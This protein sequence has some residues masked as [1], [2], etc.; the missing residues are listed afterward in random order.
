M[1]QGWGQ[2]AGALKGWG[3]VAGEAPGGQ[4][5]RNGHAEVTGKRKKRTTVEEIKSLTG[6]SFLPQLPPGL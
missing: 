2:R 1:E 5:D 6:H 4:G 3:G